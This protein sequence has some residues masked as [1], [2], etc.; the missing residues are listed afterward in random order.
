MSVADKKMVDSLT[1]VT[2]AGTGAAYTATVPG[3]TALTAGVSFIMV[4]HTVS[5][6][7]APTLNV[8]GLGA[9]TIRRRLS[10]LGTGQQAGYA[11]N[12]LG[13]G[14]PFRVIYDG[15]YW[16][17]EGQS[18]PAAVDIYGTV[19]SATKATQ[20]ASGNVIT[21][22]YATKTYVTDAINTAITAAL[23]ASY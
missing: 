9:K 15:T 23:E 20:D 11:A 8:N 21:D 4:M 18:K 14:L 12:W 17:V 19:A 1:A 13:S 16:I 7:T 22:T 2:T 10:N 5:T 3:I 6:S